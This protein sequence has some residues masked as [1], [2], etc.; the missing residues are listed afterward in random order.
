MTHPLQAR[1]TAPTIPNDEIRRIGVGHLRRVLRDYA[2]A[3]AII[4]L[5]G[6]FVFHSVMDADPSPVATNSEPESTPEPIDTPEPLPTTVRGTPID[7]DGCIVNGFGNE[8]CGDAARAYCDILSRDFGSWDSQK[9]D[10][11]ESVGWSP[12]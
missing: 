7:Y 8:L 3:L 2:V 6:G 4:A 9:Q 11:C 1:Q 5:V 10:I 12:Q